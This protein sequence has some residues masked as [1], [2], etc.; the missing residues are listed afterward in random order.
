[1]QPSRSTSEPTTL[2][3]GPRTQQQNEFL[4]STF[5]LII[6]AILV[7][8]VYVVHIRPRGDSIMA[9]QFARMRVE[10]AYV[11]ERSL[12]IVVHEYEPEVCIILM[13]WSLILLGH[14]MINNR[15]QR[16]LLASGLLNVPP[17]MR[18]LPKDTREYARQ[19][20]ALDPKLQ[21]L[22]LPRAIVASL[23]RFGSTENIHDAA[24]AGRSVCES[25]AERLDSELSMVRY[26]VW[27]IPA[28]GFVGT[29]RGIGAALQ[30]AHQAVSGNISGVTEALGITFNATF[31]ALTSS[32]IVMFFLHQLQLAQERMV[33]DTEGYL[34]Q[35]LLRHMRA[36]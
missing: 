1:M 29:V 5:A 3:A 9:E 24:E 16:K 28:I 35:H 10:P 21:Q 22:L 2:R 20:E 13:I 34:D 6:T 32:I 8:A 14:R 27:A 11:P 7:H 25:E 33:L 23:E 30:Q 26:T 15:E 12:Y 17:G 31:T 18:I 36:S 4:F 19:M